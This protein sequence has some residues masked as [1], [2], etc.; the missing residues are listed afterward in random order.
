MNTFI[1]LHYQVYKDTIECVNSIF[2]SI[3]R[4]DYNIVIVDNHSPNNSSLIL[5]DKYKDNPKVTVLEQRKNL[6]FAKGNNV[7]CQYAFENYNPDFY[8]VINNDTIIEDRMFVDQIQKIYKQTDFDM[9]GPCIWSI[10]DRV[11]QNP[12]PNP[13]DSMKKS[14]KA[15]IY[16]ILLFVLNFINKDTLLIE[17]VDNKRKLKNKKRHTCIEEFETNQAVKLHGAAIIFSKKYYLKYHNAFDPRT[18]MYGEEDIL[19]SRV[20]RHEL[21]AIY[22]PDLKILHKEDAASNSVITSNQLR[23]RF[24]FKHSIWSSF[25]L[26]RIYIAKY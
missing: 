3:K 22:N 17:Y 26:L 4:D 15:L 12:V 11:D 16:N 8:I 19:Y 9:L 14:F 21:T 18:F 7:G 6:G 10:N 23:R 1:I 24:K 13:T 20:R 25:V 5:Q 2:D